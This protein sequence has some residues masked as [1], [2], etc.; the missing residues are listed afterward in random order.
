MLPMPVSSTHAQTHRCETA[1]R[2]YYQTALTED[3][4]SSPLKSRSEH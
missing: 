2:I 1:L 4:D 3:D